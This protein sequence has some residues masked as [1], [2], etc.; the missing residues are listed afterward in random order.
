LPSSENAW[1]AARGQHNY[2]HRWPSRGRGGRGRGRGGTGGARR[3]A[4]E[5]GGE[6][7]ADSGGMAHSA[8]EGRSR[9]A[10]RGTRDQFGA[11]PGGSAAKRISLVRAGTTSGPESAG[12]LLSRGMIVR[13][14]PKDKP[15]T[16]GIADCTASNVSNED[17]Q[18][19]CAGGTS[20]SP[21]AT[22]LSTVNR[23]R[24]EAQKPGEV[25][26][27]HYYHLQLSPLSI[28]GI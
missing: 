17:F 15:G 26:K 9:Q 13:L 22:Q 24:P 14:G 16:G 7:Q 23:R 10:K 1:R 6:G 28:A 19:S 3:Q 2:K 11:T 8:G 5:Q 12:S 4:D 25:T 18:S 27:V 21:A 20:P